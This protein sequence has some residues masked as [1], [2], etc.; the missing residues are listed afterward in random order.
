MKYSNYLPFKYRPFM[1]YVP[2]RATNL[3]TSF[4]CAAIR[5]HLLIIKLGVSS[6]NGRKREVLST[7]E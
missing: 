6:V 1:P 7:C 4:L 3:L 2:F 5:Q